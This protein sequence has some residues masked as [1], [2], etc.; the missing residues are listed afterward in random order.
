[1]KAEAVVF[2]EKGSCTIEEREFDET[3][4]SRQVL[5]RNHMSLI[6]PGTE[7]AIFKK[8]HRGFDGGGVSFAR[9]PFYP[10]YAAVGEVI[11]A[12]PDAEN[13]AVGDRV[14]HRGSH[15]TYSKTQEN[16]CIKLPETFDPEKGTFITFLQIAITALHVAPACY[17]ENIVVVGMG[18][19][20]NLAA[21]LYRKTGLGTV[22]GA[23]MIQTRLELAKSVNAVH[24]AFDIQE[25]P[26]TEW[27]A[28]LGDYGA[29]LVIDAVGEASSIESC[30][31]AAAHNGRVV[32]LGSP[33][34]KM[35]ID[36]YHD[37]H[38]TGIQIIGAHGQVVGDTVRSR[39]AGILLRLLRD[40]EIRVKELISHRISFVD[41][42][43]AYEGLR[44]H[45]ESHVAVILRYDG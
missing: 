28:H 42:Q 30:I 31:K 25:K 36:P 20:G 14:Q 18:L 8:T 1:M 26:L 9:Y 13:L 22:A 27:V 11:A 7:L 24:V 5:I 15:G 44:D 10:G 38:R 6:S 21:Q 29:E 12:A 32:L 4:Q 34:T 16:G 39:D 3:L 37:I 33:R 45:P 23:D 41:A 19:V 40:G 2:T 43:S 17:S 35:E